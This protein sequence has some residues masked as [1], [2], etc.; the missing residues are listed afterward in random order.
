[1]DES[2]ISCPMTRAQVIDAYFM[3]HRAK[4]I[5][6]AAFLDRLD[7]GEDAGIG[8]DFRMSAFQRALDILKDEGPGRARR[9]LGAFSDPTREPIPAASMQGATGAYQAEG[10]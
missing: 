1:M 2:K 5:D 4:L 10:R 7:R 3:E 8:Q 9:V 6:I